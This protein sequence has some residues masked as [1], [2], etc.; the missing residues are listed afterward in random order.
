M[1]GTLVPVVVHQ[2]QLPHLHYSKM[3]RPVFFYYFQ[4]GGNIRQGLAQPRYG[5]VGRLDGVT[6]IQGLW[7]GGGFKICPEPVAD[8]IQR[9]AVR[10]ALHQYTGWRCG[11]PAAIY[12]K[13]LYASQGVL[14]EG[15]VSFEG[16]LIRREAWHRGN[17]GHHS[18]VHVT[19]RV[20]ILT[21]RRLGKFIEEVA[22][23][24]FHGFIR[25]Y[26][27]G[28]ATAGVCGIVY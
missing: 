7:Q 19:S 27:Q 8:I 15:L 21:G 9:G 14:D 23:P 13:R 20:K 1:G 5:Q 24:G 11:K 12:L 4:V 3:Y 22:D 18:D 2:L 16:N 28:E 10:E 26:E 6:R 17:D 25:A